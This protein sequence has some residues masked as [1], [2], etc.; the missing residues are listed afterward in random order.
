MQPITICLSSDNNYAQHGAVVI[1]SILANHHT[2]TP[3]AFH[4][5]DGGISDENKTKLQ[6]VV[7]KY[8]HVQLTFHTM[9]NAYQ[10]FF[11]DRHISH[12]AYY[13]L[14]IDQI[15]PH[16]DKAIYLDTDIVVLDDIELLWNTNLEDHALAAV[17]DVGLRK[18]IAE[19]KKRLDMPS[20]AHYINSGILIMN[21][22][23][24]REKQ[25]GEAILDYLTTHPNLP[26]HDQDA[27][28]AVLW[29]DT[30]LLHPRWNT[31]KG[32]FHY[33]Y[34]KNRTDFLPPLFIEAAKNP[35][36]IHFTGPIKPWH[37]ACGMPYTET[38]YQHLAKTPFKGYTPKDRSLKSLLKRW[39]WKLKQIIFTP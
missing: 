10:E 25:I 15:L 28:N 13:R 33:Y 24:W 35:A 8:D 20:D 4:Y 17:E 26:Y 34:K 9:G 3:I 16:T 22:V 37:Y 39:E 30:L 21:L 18:K 1:E 5:L 36:I 38:Y 23:V 7:D 11:V 32:I 31:Y 14:K 29:N 12:A 6:Q 19:T 2:Q 27:L